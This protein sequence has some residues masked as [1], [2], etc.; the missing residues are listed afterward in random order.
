[1]HQSFIITAHPSPGQSGD[2][3]DSRGNEPCFRSAGQVPGFCLSG[4]SCIGKA[5]KRAVVLP[6]VCSNSAGL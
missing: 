6:T 3:R 1:M 5:E 4:K 2:S